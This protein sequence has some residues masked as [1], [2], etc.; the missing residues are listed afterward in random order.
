MSIKLCQPL[1]DGL[2]CFINFFSHKIPHSMLSR[3]SAIGLNAL[4]L[5]N[6]IFPKKLRKK[7][8]MTLETSWLPTEA[9]RLLIMQE[10]ALKMNCRQ[11][12]SKPADSSKSLQTKLHC[13]SKVTKI[14]F[15][16]PATFRISL[17]A[18]SRIFEQLENRLLTERQLPCR[19]NDC[20]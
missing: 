2:V 18:L 9:P 7:L 11:K 13:I 12:W 14:D 1:E 10:T 16:A 6:I 19:S 4:L 20:I 3:H 8:K 17:H 15:E 5:Q